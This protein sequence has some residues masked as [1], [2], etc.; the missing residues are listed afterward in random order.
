MSG[1]IE[2]QNEPQPYYH[3]EQHELFTECTIA[4]ALIGISDEPGPLDLFLRSPRLPEF[5]LVTV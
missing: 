1:L 2:G 5:D 3:D 4:N